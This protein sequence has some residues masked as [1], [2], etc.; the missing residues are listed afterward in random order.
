MVAAGWHSERRLGDVFLLT[1]FIVYVRHQLPGI[2]GGA[3][4]PCQAPFTDI[5]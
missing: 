1:T 3:Y 4:I 5:N 2:L